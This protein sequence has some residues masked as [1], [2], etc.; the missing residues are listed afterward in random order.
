L[1]V[2][3]NKHPQKHDAD[4]ATVVAARRKQLTF[5]IC[6]GAL[7]L[8]FYGGV[9][10]VRVSAVWALAYVTAQLL[11]GLVGSLS[12]GRLYGWRRTAT[13]AVQT[14]S[15][16]VF[17]VLTPALYLY[18]GDFG[19][20]CGA[21]LL[22]GGI[23]TVLQSCTRSRAGFLA[24]AGPFFVYALCVPLMAWWAKA[25]QHVVL[26]LAPGAVMI[27]ACS[28]Q[29]WRLANRAHLAEEQATAELSARE[30]QAL[31]DKAFLDAVVEHTPAM[32]VVK[33]AVSG[34]YRVVNRVA[35][36]IL[37]R[38]A[39]SMV[40]K[41]DHEIFPPHEAD[42]FAAADQELVAAGGSIKIES[43]L[44]ASRHGV[45]ELCTRKVLLR[46]PDGSGL[47]VVLS[48][49]ITEERATAAALAA[50]VE[51]AQAAS[52][53]KSAFLAT[54]SH[55]IRTPLN[56]VLGM[57]HAMM[58][59]E[60][61]PVQRKR[62]GV[63][64]ESGSVLLAILN[65]VLDL[66]K[67][68]AGK[69]ELEVIDFD[70]GEVVKGAHSA[71]TDLA[72]RKGLSFIFTIESGARGVYRGDPTRLRQIL[73]NLISNALK[74]TETG[75]VA[76]RVKREGGH[77]C[78]RVAD[79]GIGMSDEQVKQLF[80]K[81]S[82][83]DAS[84]TRRFGGTGLGL[85]IC[86][87]LA[88]MMGGDIDV[89]TAPGRGSV[90]RLSLDLERVGEPGSLGEAAAPSPMAASE[91]P[92][93]RV[94][95]AEDNTVNQLVL[96]ALLHQAGIEP[97]IVENGREAVEAWERESWDLVLMDM[98]MPE[99]DGLEATRTIRAAEARLHRPRTPIIALTANAMTHQVDE[100]ARCGMDGHVAKPI[101]AGT[102]FAT[103]ERVLD[104][105]EADGWGLAVGQA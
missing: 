72:N 83:A 38:T 90:F 74:F 30:A 22:A 3:S 36:L 28:L 42:G 104:A 51:E 29:V 9:L 10:G 59:D 100:Y 20:V 61:T 95:A 6:M 34:R 73:Y 82:Q 67:I 76:V 49:D 101:D 89:E 85:A 99:M 55:E 98:H 88:R 62:L 63:I 105:A 84:T 75:E 64:Q 48:E 40:G 87:E 43:E 86:Q 94:L 97:V 92:P 17:G 5:R 70:L 4:L 39:D 27:V 18:M 77:L 96:K 53:T 21:F 66:S 8:V 23:L 80:S 65:D 91:F 11:E 60:L 26:G 14:L 45:R 37:G 13:L 25:P 52:L 12:Q 71:F 81:F 1:T 58:A 19:L 7:I 102:L 93:L 2:R 57:A 15:A 32:L 35:E 24:T 50:A 46:N 78:F 103:L 41:T 33:D 68:E 54:M 56:G 79:S 69:L 44:V 47:I 31:A 16:A